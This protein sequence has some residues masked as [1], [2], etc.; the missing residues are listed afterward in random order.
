MCVSGADGDLCRPTLYTK[1]SS[2]R[3]SCESRRASFS[4]AINTLNDDTRKV[5]DVRRGE[6]VVVSSVC[7]CVSSG[8]ALSI[9]GTA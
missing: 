8:M 6:G 9:H 4:E 1:P 3:N 7:V 2:N 5:E